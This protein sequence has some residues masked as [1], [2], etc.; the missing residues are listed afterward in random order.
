M[1]GVDFCS[2]GLQT[3]FRSEVVQM[4]L[5]DGVAADDHVRGEFVRLA[6]MDVNCCAYPSQ[7]CTAPN[8]NKTI[9]TV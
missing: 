1:P 8:G 2:A 7:F 6:S 5:L 4:G 9:G 3:E